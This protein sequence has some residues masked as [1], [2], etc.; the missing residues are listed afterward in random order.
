MLNRQNM[1]TGS[2]RLNIKVVYLYIF[3]LYNRV[4]IFVPNCTCKVLSYAAMM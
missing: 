2:Y 1:Y 4:D 3:L